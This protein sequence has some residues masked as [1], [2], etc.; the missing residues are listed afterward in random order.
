MRSLVPARDARQRSIIQHHG[1]RSRIDRIR[2]KK[3]MQAFL[4]RAGDSAIRAIGGASISL[5]L[6]VPRPPLVET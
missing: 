1:R 3:P 5:G 6:F 2:S 4:T